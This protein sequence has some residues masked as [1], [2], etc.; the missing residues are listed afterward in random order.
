MDASKSL[1]IARRRFENGN[2]LL[3]LKK[4]PAARKEFEVALSIYDKTDAHKETAE[5]LNNIAITLIKDERPEDAKG[6]FERAYE[7][8]K[9]GGDRPQ[10]L[11]NTLYNIIGLGSALS[12]E[13]FEKYFLEM[14]VVGENLGGEHADIVSREQAIYDRF[15]EA[16]EKKQKQSEEDALARSSPSAA[17][18]HLSSLGKPCVIKVKFALHGL[19][20]SVTEFSFEDSGTRVKL[21][22]IVPLDD[23]GRKV[24][25]GEIEFAAQYDTVREFFSE[26]VE[27]GGSEPALLEEAFEHVKKFMEAVAMVR[28]DIGFCV[29]KR[30]FSVLMMALMNA[31]DEP[32]EIYSDDA[33]KPESTLTLT[34]EDSMLVNMMLSTRH[35]LYK[36]ILLSAK[37]SLDEENYSLCI[38]DSV[39]GFE[40]FT[41]LLLKKML[42]ETEKEDYITLE[43]PCLRERLKLLKKV[44]SGV[45]SSD[46][47]LEHFLGE[48]GRDMDDVLVYYDDIMGND[49]RTIG[50]Y[51]AVKTLKAVNSAIYNL[52]SLYDI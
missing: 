18:E 42:P 5:A 49:G 33:H 15:V 9:E 29:G 4:Y 11:F 1:K 44:I 43:N 3:S 28:E 2:Y 40:A 38:V 14:K 22:G 10:S 8:K 32:L 26:K 36:L 51:E 31:Y 7:Q 25:T 17:L 20:V 35:S 19:S 48:V 45:E 13:E 12:E 27:N 47:P 46:Q 39:A 23:L 52:K 21:S 30:E 34:G 6:F 41:D 50:A 37:R 24:S 16:R